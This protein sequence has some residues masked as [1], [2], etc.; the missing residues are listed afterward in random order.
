MTA[1]EFVKRCCPEIKI[2]RCDD[3]NYAGSDLLLIPHPKHGITI[4]FIPQCTSIQ[5]QFFLYENHYISLVR[6]LN[7]MGKVY[8][9]K[10]KK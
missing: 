7:K 10:T 3:S 9:N 8:N 5:N 4:M 6:E 2:V 1:K